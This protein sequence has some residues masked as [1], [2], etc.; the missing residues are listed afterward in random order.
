MNISSPFI[1][2]KNV[3]GL[4]KTVKETNSEKSR[5]EGWQETE[6]CTRGYKVYFL[7]ILFL[8]TLTLFQ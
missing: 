1:N 3:R 2:E 4:K 6:S 8:Y 5:K 7:Y